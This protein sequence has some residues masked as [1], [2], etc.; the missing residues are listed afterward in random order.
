MRKSFLF[1]ALL[2]LG[3]ATLLAGCGE[4]GEKAVSED[5]A[6]AIDYRQGAFQVIGWHFGP[7]GGM[8]KGEIDYDADLFA[9]NAERIAQVAPMLLEGFADKDQ[10]HIGSD[11]KAAIWE[12]W[13]TFEQG[14]SR[15]EQRAQVLAETAQSGDLDEI[16]PKFKDVAETC[17]GCHDEFRVE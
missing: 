1:T 14:M 6:K 9:R 2:A 8:V 5:A 10:T 3:S 11:A 12:D 7:L 16:R 13:E 4:S 15:F 17:K